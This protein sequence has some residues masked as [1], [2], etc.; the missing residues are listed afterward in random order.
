MSKEY[1]TKGVYALI[2]ARAGS[3]QVPDKNILDLGGVPLLGYSIAAAR[4]CPLI[5]EVFVT[6]DS[7][8]Y[9]SIAIELGA[10]APFLRPDEISG[11]NSLD[12]E[13]FQH[14]ITWCQESG[15]VVPEYIVHLRPSTPLRNPLVV[16]Q[17]IEYIQASE[18]ATALRSCQKTSLTP[19]KLFYNDSGFMKPY[20]CDERFLESYNQPRQA[21]PDTYVPNGYVDIV[22]TEVF[23]DSDILHGDKMLHWETDPTADIDVIDDY[24]EATKQLSDPTFS[25][26][27]N[28]LEEYKTVNSASIGIMQGRV[29]PESLNELQIFPESSWLRESSR[30]YEI[31]FKHIELLWDKARAIKNFPTIQS[32]ISK[33]SPITIP[34]MCVDIVTTLRSNVEIACEIEKIVEF[35]GDKVPSILVIPLLGNMNVTKGEELKRFMVEIAQYPVADILRAQNVILSLEL[36]M[37]AK[38]ISRTFKLLDDPLFALCLDTGNLWHSS[39]TP[40][41]DLLLLLPYVNHVHIKDKDNNGDNV[42]LGNGIVDFNYFFEKLSEKNYSQLFTLETKYFDDPD[43]EASSNLQFI[44]KYKYFS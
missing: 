30:M 34:S 18:D 22:K 21:F 32:E 15:T 14:F 23:M 44:K 7:E 26:L 8:A 13:F 29:I 9:Q 33:A 31:G 3:K 12:I 24:V 17:A 20:L 5:D 40:K 6:T 35:F 11:D 19:Y 38:E 10:K 4:M 37:D 41:E 42:L 1:E 25:S 2:P 28:Y 16:Q 39:T 27:L 36:E 43:M